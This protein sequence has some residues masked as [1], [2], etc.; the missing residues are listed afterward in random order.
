[1]HQLR[2]TRTTWTSFPNLRRIFDVLNCHEFHVVKFSVRP[3]N[4]ADID[5]LEHFPGL[6]VDRNWAAGAN[7]SKTF[8]GVYELHA[9]SSAVILG[10]SFV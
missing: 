5:I 4:S 2:A 3:L 1:M 6:W 9:V 10:K 8:H 7:P